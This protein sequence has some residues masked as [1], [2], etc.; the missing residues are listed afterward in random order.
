MAF[1][2]EIEGDPVREIERAIK[3]LMSKSAM[4]KYG[5]I[6]HTNT[7]DRI[8]E[9]VD[10]SGQPFIGLSESYAATKKGP[11]IL[12]ETGDLFRTLFVEGREGEAEVGTRIDYGTW[13]QDGTDDGKLPQ[14]EWLSVTKDDEDAIALQAE[15]LWEGSFVGR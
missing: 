6:V 11:G 9:G 15:F 10:T 1:S 12:R 7:R 3:R 2:I 14:R 8:R 4:M 13:N 5:R